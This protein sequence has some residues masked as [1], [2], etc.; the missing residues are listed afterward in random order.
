MGAYLGMDVNVPSLLGIFIAQLLACGSILSGF[1]IPFYQGVM[2]CAAIILIYSTLSGMW[3]VVMTDAIQSSVIIV[4]IPV[5]AVASLMLLHEQG[6][7]PGQIYCQPFIP[8]GTF[9]KFIYLVVPFLVAIS[10]SYDAYLRFQSA[11]DARTARWGA[12]IAGILVIMIGI[13]SSTVGVA[14]RLLFPELKEGIFSHMVIT[15][16][17]PVLA[18]ITVAAVLGAAMS[19]GAG[20]LISLGAT[21]SRDLFNRFLFPRYELDELPYSK[22]ISRL[23]VG[24]S[25]VAGVLLSFK[26][27]NILD[28]IIIF[29]YP[30]MG[31]LLIPLL[32]GL[33]WKGATRK[34]AYAAIFV[35]GIIG[36]GAFLS[37]VYE[38]FQK[39]IK[40]ELGLFIAYSV[41]LIVVIVVS[42]LDKTKYE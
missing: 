1:G 33:L 42:K 3:G 5:V 21:F 12:V 7:N 34:G 10:V 26:V 20:L 37:G 8:K 30:Y 36:I 9:P 16:L 40:S 18:G 28:A 19:S 23:T 14:G 41:S 17:P 31:S 25:V 6:I 29:N 38:P 24:L 4:S 35:G 15:S 11:K 2:I 22:L 39:V 32:V 13:F 27:T